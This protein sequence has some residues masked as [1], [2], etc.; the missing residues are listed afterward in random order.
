[1]IEGEDAQREL[2]PQPEGPT[3]PI[4]SPGLMLSVREWRTS[5]PSSE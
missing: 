5:S 3:M 1:M 2:L 4:F